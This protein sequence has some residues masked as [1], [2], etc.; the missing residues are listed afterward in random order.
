MRITDLKKP[1]DETLQTEL[2]ILVD[3]LRVLQHEL[4]EEKLK[5]CEEYEL[6]KIQINI[7]IQDMTTY[8]NNNRYQ[9]DF[10]G[11]FHTRF[12]DMK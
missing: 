1:F 10:F 7:F 5:A 9:T 8:V 2:N 11:M 6:Y 3:E 12:C 4:E